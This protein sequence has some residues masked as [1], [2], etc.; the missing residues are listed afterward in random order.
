MLLCPSIRS[1]SKLDK[2]KI[3]FSKLMPIQS[4]RGKT[5]G[6]GGVD[7]TPLGIRRVKPNNCNSGLQGSNWLL[8]WQGKS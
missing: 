3:L 4:Y 7:L 1:I 2:P 8:K 5:L 6:G